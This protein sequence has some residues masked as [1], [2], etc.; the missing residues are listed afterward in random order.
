MTD[1]GVLERIRHCD[2]VGRSGSVT[3]VLPNLIEGDGPNLPLGALCRV[4]TRAA[5]MAEVIAVEQ[6]FVRLAPYQPALA[7]PLGTRIEALPQREAVAV[8]DGLCFGV[9]VVPT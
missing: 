5:L 6:R 3:R 8:G 4:G 1:V 2:P 9:Q 7:V